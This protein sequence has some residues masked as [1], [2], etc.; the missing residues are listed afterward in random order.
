MDFATHRIARSVYELTS[1]FAEQNE[2]L[3][4]PVSAVT[5]KLNGKRSLHDLA[6][7]SGLDTFELCK[8]VV[9]LEYLGLVRPVSG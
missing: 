7:I 3:N 4:L 5:S 2:K 9:A 8:T 1:H 6:Q